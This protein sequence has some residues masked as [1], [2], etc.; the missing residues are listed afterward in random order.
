MRRFL[1]K[2]FGS[3]LRRRSTFVAPLSALADGTVGHGRCHP[4]R[5]RKS[6]GRTRRHDML[7]RAF[8]VAAVIVVAF[9]VACS[10]GGFAPA[11]AW[12]PP[13][14]VTRRVRRRSV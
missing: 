2:P 3:G 6:G 8:G 11:S 10:G 12:P 5:H 4:A 13:E 7:C 1:A 14:P 9:G